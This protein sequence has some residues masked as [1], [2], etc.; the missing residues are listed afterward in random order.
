VNIEQE[1]FKKMIKTAIRRTNKSDD[2]VRIRSAIEKQPGVLLSLNDYVSYFL[3]IKPEHIIDVKFKAQRFYPCLDELFYE[4]ISL[5][6]RRSNDDELI[7]SFIDAAKKCKN[8]IAQEKFDDGT[9]ISYEK[10]FGFLLKMLTKV[11]CIFNNPKE[12]DIDDNKSMLKKYVELF[13]SLNP[14]PDNPV[15]LPLDIIKYHLLP[16]IYENSK[17]LCAL[18]ETCR[19]FAKATRVQRREIFFKTPSPRLDIVLIDYPQREKGGKVLHQLHEKSNPFHVKHDYHYNYY[20][21]LENSCTQLV[22]KYGLDRSWFQPIETISSNLGRVNAFLCLIDLG[23]DLNRIDFGLSSGR[24]RFIKEFRVYYATISDS[25][26]VFDADDQRK[27][28]CKI[29]TIFNQAVA[30]TPYLGH[31]L[32]DDSESTLSIFSKLFQQESLRP[33]AQTNEERPDERKCTIF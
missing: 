13:N 18:S 19:F 14:L 33:M 28:E 3:D 8:R 15:I 32:S 29:R 17:S 30:V 22:L 2:D 12:S 20:F 5:L 31:I 11:I 9:S 26:K 27:V 25:N 21:P 24:L 7:K 23:N 6:D 1:Q 10:D 16:Y 4:A